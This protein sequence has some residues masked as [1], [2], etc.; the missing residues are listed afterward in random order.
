MRVDFVGLWPQ[1]VLVRN[2]LPPQHTLQVR[3]DLDHRAYMPAAWR[4]DAYLDEEV[5]DNYPDS[6]RRTPHTPSLLR[7]CG[8]MLIYLDSQH[9]LFACFGPPSGGGRGGGGQRAGRAAVAPLRGGKGAQGQH[10]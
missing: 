10:G 2:Q 4:V 1:L 3:G 9:K 7:L 8:R 6:Q 5:G